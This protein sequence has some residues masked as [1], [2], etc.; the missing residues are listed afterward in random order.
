MRDGDMMITQGNDFRILA[1][2]VL[3]LALAPT[4]F[5]SIPSQGGSPAAKVAV[6]FSSQGIPSPSDAPQREI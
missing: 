3:L 6:A 4:V 1:K 5:Y 2:V